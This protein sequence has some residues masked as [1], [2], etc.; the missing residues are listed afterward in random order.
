M[1]IEIAPRAAREAETCVRWWR[2]NRPDAADLF[3]RELRA[4][5]DQIRS[6]PNSGSLY[7]ALH[8]REHRRALMPVTRFHVYYRLAADD[9]VRVVAIWS[10]QRG[11]GPRV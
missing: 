3:E 8:G 5:L 2:E 1:R 10:A 7:Q 11:R 6:A 4:V 9:V